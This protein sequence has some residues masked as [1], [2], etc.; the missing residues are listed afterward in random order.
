MQAF[1]SMSNANQSTINQTSSKIRNAFNDYGL[2]QAGTVFV[3]QERPVRLQLPIIDPDDITIAG[4]FVAAFPLRGCFYDIDR[5]VTKVPADFAARYRNVLQ[6]IY[7]PTPEVFQVAAQFAN[8]PQI[9]AMCRSR[10]FEGKLDFWLGLSTPGGKNELSLASL[11]ASSSPW[12]Q[13]VTIAILGKDDPLVD[14]RDNLWYLWLVQSHL[15]VVAP[16][17]WR[18]LE[19]EKRGP[20]YAA[21]QN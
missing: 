3:S 17:T 13:F 10:T 6:L 21:T 9:I 19:S 20:A 2:K 7:L 4:L 1:L 5:L 14:P 12:A 18:A 16:K 8:D 11:E 15:S